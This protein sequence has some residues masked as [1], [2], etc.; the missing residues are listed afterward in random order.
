MT[1]YPQQRKLQGIEFNLLAALTASHAHFSFVGVFQNE[2]ITWDATLLTLERYHAEQPHSSQAV[3]RS[4]FLEVGLE[5][6]AQT[7]SGRTLRV[8]I[9]VAQ[10]DEPTILRSIIMIRQYK[11]LH[12]GRHEFG[13]H[14]FPLASAGS[15]MKLF[16]S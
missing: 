9:D 15:E 16:L 4:P 5:V 8:V 7:I 14:H 2:E 1:G 11:R 10:I 12:I 6:G 3:Q 13:F